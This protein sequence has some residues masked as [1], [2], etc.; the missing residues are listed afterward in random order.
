MASITGNFGKIKYGTGATG[1][2]SFAEVRSFNIEESAGIID[3]SA[4]GDD[5]ETHHVGMKKWSGTMECH[6]DVTDVNGQ[7]VLRAGSSFAGKFFPDGDATGKK[8]YAGTA[9]V[10]QI[11]IG[12]K[13]G[14]TVTFECS[15]QGNGPLTFETVA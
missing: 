6:Y 10:Q 7:M 9:T 11:T 2:G 4:M 3:S 13:L 5:Y 15:F 8:F 1:S 12:A 14:D